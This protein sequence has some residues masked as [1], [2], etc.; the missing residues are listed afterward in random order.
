[1]KTVESE[2]T[3]NS[4]EDPVLGIRSM[5]Q[6]PLG[7]PRLKWQRWKPLP[8]SSAL[9]STTAVPTTK[10]TDTFGFATDATGKVTDIDA[11]EVTEIAVTHAGSGYKVGDT[12][13]VGDASNTSAGITGL[14]RPST[15]KR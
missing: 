11:V 5:R 9:I 10:W 3:V 1:M 13:T 15:I 7:M 14:F 6:S 2:M 4:I 12:F 8:R